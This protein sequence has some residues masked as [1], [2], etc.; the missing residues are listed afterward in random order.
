[1]PSLVFFSFATVFLQ[2]MVVLL[3]PEVEKLHAC[4]NND[5]YPCD[6]RNVIA[7]RNC[8]PAMLYFQVSTL[9]GPKLMLSHALT[10]IYVKNISTKS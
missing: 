9:E 10:Q 8:W 5:L 7:I 4:N 3:L 6:V 1:M 2:K